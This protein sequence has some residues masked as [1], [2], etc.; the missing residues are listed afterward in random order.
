ML[1]GSSWYPLSASEPGNTANT[2]AY[3]GSVYTLY[4][5]GHSA[6]Q[7]VPCATDASNVNTGNA[8]FGSQD[9][10]EVEIGGKS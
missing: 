8:R 7:H 3:S 5:L 6:M 9:L 2:I 4:T 1:T 10:Q